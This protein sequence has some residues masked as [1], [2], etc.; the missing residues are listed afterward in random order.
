REIDGVANWRGGEEPGLMDIDTLTIRRLRDALIASGR[1]SEVQGERNPVPG[2]EASLARVAPFVETM[3]LMMV[4]DEAHTETES[5]VIRGA[6]RTLTHGLL[7]DS[8]LS[9]MLAGFAEQ[10][11]AQGVEA[12]LQAIGNR[13][14][15]DRIDRETGFT[16]AAA[17]ALADE[18]VA[19]EELTLLE[20]IGEWFGLSSRRRREILQ[21][22]DAGA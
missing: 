22:F 21:Q 9:A 3:Y 17:V 2:R 8:A 10:R 16:L 12:R 1:V 4:I 11:A 13:I 7:D 20:S 15:A 18:T 6:M 5:A 19:P 14:C